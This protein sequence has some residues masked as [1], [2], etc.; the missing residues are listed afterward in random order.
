MFSIKYKPLNVNINFIPEFT[1]LNITN[2]KVKLARFDVDDEEG[3]ATITIQKTTVKFMKEL[4]KRKEEVN[5]TIEI[6][7]YLKCRSIYLMDFFLNA[8]YVTVSPF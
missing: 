7:M 4:G 3:S 1:K 8:L 5:D 6:K 2:E